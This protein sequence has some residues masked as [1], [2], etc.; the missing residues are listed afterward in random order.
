MSIEAGTR[1]YSSEGQE[2]YFITDLPNETFLVTPILVTEDGE[3]VKGN[4]AVWDKVFLS[5]PREQYNEEIEELKKQLNELNSGIWK[6]KEELRAHNKTKGIEEL[7]ELASGNVTHFVLVTDGNTIS[8]EKYE[9]DWC[10]K[11]LV[12]DVYKE[13]LVVT[14]NKSG[15]G[16]RF[17]AYLATSYEEAQQ[18]ASGILAKMAISTNSLYPCSSIDESVKNCG[19]SIPDSILGNYREEKAKEL[20]RM[21]E[22]FETSLAKDRKDLADDEARLASIIEEM[23]KLAL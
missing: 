9:Q 19:I 22:R 1:V 20:K 21:K 11:N 12:W 10:K 5:P 17:T 3:E 2:G 18:I 4:P 16:A 6:A 13:K 15:Y 14:Q 8:I 23:E 7:L